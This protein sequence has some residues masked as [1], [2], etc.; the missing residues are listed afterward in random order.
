MFTPEYQSWIVNPDT[1]IANKPAG[2][3]SPLVNWR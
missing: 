1:K 3:H 2:Y